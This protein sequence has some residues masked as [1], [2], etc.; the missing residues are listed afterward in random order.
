MDASI[1]RKSSWAEKRPAQTKTR[2]PAK[3][4]SDLFL[5]N[6]IPSSFEPMVL[7][8]GRAVNPRESFFRLYF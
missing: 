1:L 5:M 7:L 6:P 2:A 8:G 3:S 4:G